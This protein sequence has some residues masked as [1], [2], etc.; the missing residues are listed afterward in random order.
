MTDDHRKNILILFAHPALQRSRVN[1]RLVEGLD[2]IERV[3]FHDLYEHYPDFD[4]DVAREQ[5]LLTEHD[6][7]VMHHPFYWYST[8]A[9]LKEWQD[10]VLTHGWAYGHDGHALEGK[11]MFNAFTAGGPEEAYCAGGYNRFTL[12]QLLAPLEQTAFLCRMRWLP[13]FAVL[14]TLQMAPEAVAGH[15]RDYRRLLQALTDGLIDLDLAAAQER[16][17]GDLDRIILEAADVR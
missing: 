12:R 9:I 5:Q 6:V 17:N 13:P 1:A 7:I 10:L 16:L 15:A 3:T 4:I 11:I 14:D 2:R 8:P